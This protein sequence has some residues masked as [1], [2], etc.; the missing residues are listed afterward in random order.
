LALRSRLRT[1]EEV[2]LAHAEPEP[3]ETLQLLLGLHA[4]G[5]RPDR[6]GAGNVDNRGRDGFGGR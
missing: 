2:S 3:V 4:F 1:A 5:D 6:Q